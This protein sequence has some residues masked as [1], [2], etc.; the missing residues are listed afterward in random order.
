MQSDHE[1]TL[2]SVSP[3]VLA[4]YNPRIRLELDS[5]WVRKHMLH[6][7]EA[8][9]NERHKVKLPGRSNWTLSWCLQQRTI[10]SY[11]FSCIYAFL[12]L[13]CWFD[14]MIKI[15]VYLGFF[16]RGGGANILLQWA[17][18]I[19]LNTIPPPVWTVWTYISRPYNNIMSDWI[20]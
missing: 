19:V 8:V 20:C 10:H 6:S 18:L 15:H 12:F 17:S 11:K 3:E 14:K 9:I 16:F 7:D 1:H 13:V 5:N 2:I 4:Q